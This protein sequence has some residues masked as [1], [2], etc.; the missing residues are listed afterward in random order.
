MSSAVETSS[1]KV[2]WADSRDLRERLVA[3]VRA[4]HRRREA[5]E[6]FGVSDDSAKKWVPWV[7]AGRSLEATK[8]P[9]ASPKLTPDEQEQLAAW[10][11]EQ[12]DRT[13][14]EYQ[15]LIRDHFDKELC[16]SAVDVTLRKLGF[17]DKKSHGM[18]PS[19]TGT[20][21]RRIARNGTDASGPSDAD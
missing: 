10:V 18:R 3:Y 20:M 9:G 17:T 4:G 19:R 8:P 7:Q 6:V 16:V 2:V 21:S 15:Q 13:L 1:T 11:R 5:A 14:R 12:P